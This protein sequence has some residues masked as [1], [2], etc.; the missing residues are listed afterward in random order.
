[1]QTFFRELFDYT[2]RCNLQSIEVLVGLGDRMP[3]KCA[4]LQS[5]LFNAHQIWNNRIAPEHKPFGVWDMHPAEE[6]NAINEVNY[7]KTLHI[8]DTVRLDETIYYQNSR[9]E[10]FKGI[11]RDLLFQVINHTTYHRGQIA[12]L[13][14]QHDIEPFLSDYIFYKR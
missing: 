11:A 9:G 5:H 10:R 1:M 2:H 14:R 7:H 4:Q 12:M 3:A 13:L 6:W 8:L